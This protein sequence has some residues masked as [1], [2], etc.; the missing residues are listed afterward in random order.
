MTATSPRSAY[1]AHAGRPTL[2]K[3]AASALAASTLTAS[4]LAALTAC[5]P[6]P[7]YQPPVVS[8]T[9]PHPTLAAADGILR[10]RALSD[11]WLTHAAD[12]ARFADVRALA[13][14]PILAFDPLSPET[15][16]RAAAFA[17]ADDRIDDG[18]AILSAARAQG[19]ETPTLIAFHAHH[20][21]ATRHFDAARAL[22]TDALT[23]FGPSPDLT[24]AAAAAFDQDPLLRAAIRTLTPDVDLSAIKALG[25]GST[26]TLRLLKGDLT[27]GAFKPDQDLGQSMYRSEIAYYRLCALLHCA[28]R[29]PHNAHVRIERRAFDDLY[30][31]TDSD[32]QRSYRG[33]LSHMTW[34]SDPQDGL[35][36][37]HGTLKAW[38]PDFVGFNI[39][40]TDA[41]APYLKL[42]SSSTALNQDAST[43]IRALAAAAPPAAPSS[44]GLYKRAQGMTIRQV[45]HQLSDLLALDFLTN[46]WD[47]FS[48]HVELF[49]ANCHFEPGGFVAIDNGASFPEWNTPR[50]TA[51]LKLSQRFS[52]RLISSLRLLDRD[53]TLARLFPNPTRQ[54]I[55]RF[56][57]FWARRA[58]LLSYVDQ[59][60]AQ[61]GAKAV[62]FFD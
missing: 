14:T 17:Y 57:I 36:Y 32:K 29:V 58:E 2:A 41:W 15:Q 1:A 10:A 9:T 25:G 53:Q 19:Q 55:K 13:I 21:I 22:T 5:A 49:G 31:R 24:A 35:S 38:V 34:T 26:V 16:Q 30:S 51:R 50:V 6:P 54:E 48:G 52:R 45:A 27:L 47:R 7:A 11:T 20:L 46:N 4:A 28:F 33:K 42:S 39:E 12:A 43:L 37:V 61:H 60:I 23:R 56:D 62:L 40:V 8:L 44:G 18:L 59:L 3:R